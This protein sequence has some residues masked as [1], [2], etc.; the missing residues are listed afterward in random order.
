MGTI[1]STQIDT[2]LD[3]FEWPDFVANDLQLRL[4]AE[5]LLRIEQPVNEE[6]VSH[7]GELVELHNDRRNDSYQVTRGEL[8]SRIYL[9]MLINRSDELLNYPDSGNELNAYRTTGEL[10]EDLDPRENSLKD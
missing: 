2:Y 4:L 8:N 9:T 10:W 6:S 7:F 5:N 3:R 1:A